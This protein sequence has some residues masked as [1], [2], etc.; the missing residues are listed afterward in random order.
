M[1]YIM[2]AISFVLFVFATSAV[3]IPSL[4]LDISDGEYDYVTDT[5]VAT[6]SSFSLY[7]LIDPVFVDDGNGGYLNTEF[8]LTMAVAPQVA[9]D[10]DL[11]SFS[12]DGEIYEVTY[13]MDYSS[14]QDNP[15]LAPHGIYDTYYLELPFTVATKMFT[16]IDAYNVEPEDNVSDEEVDLELAGNTLYQVPFLVDVSG[17]DP[18][19]VIHFDLYTYVGDKKY[20][21]PFSH[22]AES[23]SGPA[24]VPE[25]STLL[26][27]G[28]GIVGFAL[29]RR[30]RR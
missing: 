29:Y 22:D 2:L 19:Y 7:A 10:I 9:S 5:V 25:P 6:T 27:L 14:V 17:L 21:A 18:E 4:Q 13:D 12:V 30:K 11:G 3:A 28:S 24:P 16:S 23:G 1:K 8:Y 20:F 15:D 26:L